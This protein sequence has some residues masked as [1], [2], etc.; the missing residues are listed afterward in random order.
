MFLPYIFVY[1]NAWKVLK[2]AGEGWRRSA[3]PVVC[4]NKEGLHR[5]KEERN[6]LHATKRSKAD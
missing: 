1:Q 5:V 3:G 6:I 4:K 2:C